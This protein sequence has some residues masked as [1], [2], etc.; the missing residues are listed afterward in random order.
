[1]DRIGDTGFWKYFKKDIEQGQLECR[2]CSSRM[3]I[4]Q[5]S[6]LP[7]KL[8]RHL[9]SKHS[10]LISDDDVS[11]SHFVSSDGQSQIRQSSGSSK[12]K[13]D[14]NGQFMTLDIADLK[15]SRS[16]RSPIWKYFQPYPNKLEALCLICKETLRHHGNTTNLGKHFKARHPNEA[17]SLYNENNRMRKRDYS[18]SSIFNA[19]T[20]DVDNAGSSLLSSSLLEGRQ[21]SSMTISTLGSKVIKT[22]DGVKTVPTSNTNRQRTK[23]LDER[24]TKMIIMDLQPVSMVESAYFVNLMKL[25]EPGYVLPTRQAFSSD[26]LPSV[27][28]TAV[29]QIFKILENIKYVALTTELWSSRVQES[30]LS[31]TVHFISP[32]SWTLQSLLLSTTAFYGTPTGEYIT[33]E[34]E[35][36]VSEWNLLEKVHVMVADNDTNRLLSNTQL[37]WAYIPCLAHLIHVVV[38]DAM[39]TDAELTSLV[40]K[41][42][43]VVRFFK[44]LPEAKSKLQE[45]QKSLELPENKLVFYVPTRWNSIYY[46]FERMLEQI[47]AV[48]SVLTA[49]GKESM[50]LAPQDEVSLKMAISSLKP[51]EIAS[52]TM[53]SERSSSIG[54]A[55]PLIK[56]LLKM[57]NGVA[58]G[59]TKLT[60]SLI[61]GLTTSFGKIEEIEWVVAATV[62]DPRFKKFSYAEK[63]VIERATQSISSEIA[64][65]C[66]SAAAVTKPLN[67]IEE[68]SLWMY[69]DGMTNSLPEE[70]EEEIVQQ[71]LVDGEFQRYLESPPISREE[72]PLVYWKHHEELFPTLSNLAKKYM[73]VPMTSIPCERLFSK[74]GDPFVQK[75]ANLKPKHLNMMLFL[76][77]NFNYAYINF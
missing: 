40:E 3:K 56:G 42:G 35:R 32:T 51:F 45:A 22:E 37:P 58:D 71:S 2:F 6:R 14:E 61:E 31:V 9:R 70:R 47:E 69:L 16:K 60:S 74:A 52:K 25:A 29:D 39:A 73:T 48:N 13:H 65:L 63:D 55:L 57:M 17:A 20:I 26:L 11:K 24:V 67:K 43:N 76:N 15:E 75:R 38:T 50:C 44:G 62:L 59:M 64:T 1:M 36:T 72:N 49:Y 30:Y 12:I 21:G 77:R 28:K 4:G 53:S 10:D 68:D 5:I 27:Y 46:M 19:S 54:T 8:I 33:A 18:S 66:H 34:L 7:T 23:L 41:V